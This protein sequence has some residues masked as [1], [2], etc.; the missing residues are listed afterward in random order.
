MIIKFTGKI[1]YW[2][3]PSP[4]YFVTAPT[5]E[6][7]EIKLI[8]GIVTYGWGVIPTTVQIGNTVFQTS[9]FPK[10]SHYLVPIK[11]SVRDVF[12]PKKITNIILGGLKRL[13]GIPKIKVE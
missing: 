8:S 10:D 1:F 3:G 9:L 13:K 11:K 6:S 7:Q 5:D 4:F 12:F 2:R